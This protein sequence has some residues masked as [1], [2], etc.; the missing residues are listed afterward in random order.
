MSEL[1]QAGVFEWPENSLLGYEF[2]SADQPETVAAGEAPQ[3]SLAEGNREA[4]RN[5][6]RQLVRLALFV[7]EH[8]L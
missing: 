2:V 3:I 1:R 8:R 6:T 7:E 4:D 5:L